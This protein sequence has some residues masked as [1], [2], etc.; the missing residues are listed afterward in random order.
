MDYDLFELFHSIW[1]DQLD[2]LKQLLLKG[3]GVSISTTDGSGVS[4]AAGG[5]AHGVISTGGGSGS[6]IKALGGATGHGVFLVGG[7]TSGNGIHM[8]LT[9][10]LGIIVDCFL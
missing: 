6:G 9:S 3:N 2:V 4:I 8:T 7:G 1:N 10:G 5:N